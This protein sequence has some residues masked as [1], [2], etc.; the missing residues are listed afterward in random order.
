MRVDVR[1]FRRIGMVLTTAGV[2]GLWPAVAQS[3]NGNDYD[4]LFA[5]YLA[6]AKSAKP[7][8]V[9]MADLTSD[10][11]ARHVND[12]VT[13]RVVESLSATGTADSN[14]AKSGSASVAIPT[15]ASKLLAK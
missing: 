13:I 7:T 8:Q 2:C 1:L 15:P 9:W 6:A 4:L 3:Q 5:Q 12:L 14:L 11:S 10:P